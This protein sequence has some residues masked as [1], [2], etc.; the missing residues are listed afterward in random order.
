MLRWI[1]RME[2]VKGHRNKGTKLRDGLLSKTIAQL[3]APWRTIFDFY[4]S[5]AIAPG[6]SQ[7]R[8]PWVSRSSRLPITN[9]MPATIIG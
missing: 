7:M 9:V 3:R 4:Q 5:A 6:S 2:A 8:T 1:F